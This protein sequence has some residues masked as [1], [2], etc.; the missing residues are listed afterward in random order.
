MPPIGVHSSR[1]ALLAAALCSGPVAAQPVSVDLAPIADLLRGDVRLIWMGDSYCSTY[2]SRVPA[3]AMNTWPI[4]RITAMQG[5]AARNH[6]LL[7]AIKRCEPL[8]LVQ[9]SDPLGYR[10]E[11]GN[12]TNHHFGLPVRGIQELR[13]TSD[14]VLGSDD[15]VLEFRLMN[16]RLVTGNHG[17]FSN[18][19]DRL[20]MRFLYRATTDPVDQLPAVRLQDHTGMRTDMD[21]AGSSRGFLHRGESPLEGRPP[22]PGQINAA[23]PDIDANN[24]L[25]GTN[26]V[27]L[28]ID[29]GLLGTKQ[30][31]DTAG[32]IYYQVDEQGHRVPGLYF[33][34][35]ADD[36]WAYRGF[37]DDL[38]CE[39]THDKVFTGEQLVHWLDVTTLDPD[40]P[41]VF[42][43]YLNPEGHGYNSSRALMEGMIDLADDAAAEVRIASVQ[44]LLITA[45]R[46]TFGAGDPVFLM[47]SQQRASFDIARD[48]DNVSAASIYAATDGI[49]FNGSV[50]ARTWLE[51]HGFDEF[52]FGTR[53]AD[54]VSPP[55]YGRML[56]YA[57]IHPN[58]DEGGAFFATILG[59]MLR[60]AACPGDV[61]PDGRI[62]VQDLLAVIT[63][64]GRPAGGDH[65]PADVL[66][67]AEQL[68]IILTNWGDCWPVQAPFGQP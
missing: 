42:A 20:R 10:V 27:A 48:R 18:A 52:H 11:R 13:T 60:S 58:G 32:A 8:E 24:D 30:Y 12:G 63:R 53:T 31:L 66:D 1:I 17:V 34:Y 45:H 25:E 67:V 21:L 62:D 68:K 41:V 57:G 39:H 47:E 15:E 50:E 7:Y 64:W 6:G 38:E 4:D 65:D 3:A 59:D 46:T 9:S 22:V 35:L 61:I 43:W 44:H 28:S 55:L 23:L 56:D 51:D 33:S 29:P 14:L 19:G 49:L 26:R 5:G 54:L 16:E 40:Q 36:S 2:L 37:G